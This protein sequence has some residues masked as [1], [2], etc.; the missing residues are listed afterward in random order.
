MQMFVSASCVV[1]GG[2]AGYSLLVLDA[3]RERRGFL[4]RHWMLYIFVIASA[5]FMAHFLWNK[6]GFLGSRTETAT[7]VGVAI[8]AISFAAGIYVFKSTHR[9]G[10]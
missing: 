1:F 9:G 8:M 10:I 7:F 3:A 4:A 6:H 5:V 2:I